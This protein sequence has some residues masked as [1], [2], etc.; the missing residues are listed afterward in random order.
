[1]TL[2]HPPM[3]VLQA[4]IAKWRQADVRPHPPADAKQVRDAFAA[5]G[6]IATRDLVRLYGAIGGMDMVED[7]GWMLWP[8]D[9]VSAGEARSNEF[10][11]VFSDYLIACWLFR[12]RPVS[13]D[14][15]EI[16]ADF[17]DGTEPTLVAASLDAFLDALAFQPMSVLEPRADASVQRGGTV[18]TLRGI[19][20][21]H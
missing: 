9:Q 12:A 6:G 14:V 2:Q 4:L 5:A 8:L 20:D 18:V 10:G 7:N 3:R 21:D 16:Y 17:C 15:S 1:M 13:Q 11:T 19:N